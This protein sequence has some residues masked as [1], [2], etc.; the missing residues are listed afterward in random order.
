MSNSRPPHIF[1]E[2][3]FDHF[4]DGSRVLGG[5]PFN[6][7]WHLQAFGQSPLMVSRVGRDAQ[8]EQVRAAMTA[9][10]MSTRHLQTDPTRATGQVTVTFKDGEPAYDIV[11][12]CA[13]DHIDPVP[14]EPCELLYHGSLAVRAA[15]SAT[16]LKLLRAAGPRRVFIDVNLRPPWWQPAVVQDLLAGADW[17]KLNSDE[18]AI[19]SGNPATTET[20][21][22]FLQHY[23]LRGLLVTQGARG[24]QL[25]LA[26]GE[27]LQVAPR[28]GTEVVDTVGAGDAFTAVM[29]LGLL[30]E[31]PL[32]LL[33]ARAQQFAAA[34]VGR[35][36]ATVDQQD[37]YRTFTRQWQLAE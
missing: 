4:P 5:A 18:L 23:G 21:R 31:W 24:A 8:G 35:R 37:F 30:Q 29:L 10:G 27:S 25:L 1:G 12:D 14:A 17:V 33:L 16:T 13:Y 34:V 2:V 32:P 6:V 26:D 20:G 28:P 19:L 15:V 11:A 7:A 22:A 3:L 9:W 36:G